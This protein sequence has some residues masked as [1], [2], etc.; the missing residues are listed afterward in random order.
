M[1]NAFEDEKEESEDED[2]STRNKNHPKIPSLQNEIMRFLGRNKDEGINHY[3]KMTMNFVCLLSV[4]NNE[5][6]IMKTKMKLFVSS[7]GATSSLFVLNMDWLSDRNFLN[8]I[9]MDALIYIIN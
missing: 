7:F 3:I 8:K 9:I 1:F 4:P 2:E 5:N 6:P